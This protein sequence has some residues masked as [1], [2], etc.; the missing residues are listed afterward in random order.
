MAPPQPTTVGDGAMTDILSQAMSVNFI[1]EE[2][3]N[4]PD[5]ASFENFCSDPNLSC[6]DWVAETNRILTA[7]NPNFNHGLETILENGDFHG[8]NSYTDPTFDLNSNQGF[9]Q[10]IGNSMVPIYN[11]SN[12]DGQDANY[13][14]SVANINFNQYG[15]D[16]PVSTLLQN[17]ETIFHAG[18]IFM[19]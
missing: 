4:N 18:I 1:E 10:N 6:D 7:G 9:G 15:Q 11:V 2:F 16:Y 5:L 3:Q 13:A 19:N 14:N 8:N 17:N 12:Y